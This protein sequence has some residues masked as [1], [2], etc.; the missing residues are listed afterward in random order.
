MANKR[1]V[2]NFQTQEFW[3]VH[4]VKEEARS[5]CAECNVETDWLSVEQVVVVTGIKAREIFRRVES[6]AFHYKESAEG[7]LF[8][9]SQ[10]LAQNEE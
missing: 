1:T 5:M 6:G 4:K 2:I 7:F 8:I 3:L 10:S 9:C